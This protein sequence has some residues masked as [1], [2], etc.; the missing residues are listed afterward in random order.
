MLAVK[1]ERDGPDTA[2]AM[3]HNLGLALL[4]DGKFAGADEILRRLLP[5]ER[6]K[7]RRS[8]PQA[9]RCLRVLIELLEGQGKGEEATGLLGD[10]WM[11]VGEAEENDPKRR[12]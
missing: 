10:G 9:W 12:R 5:I 3:R 6:E 7:I 8:S 2:L 11:L 4:K 1:E